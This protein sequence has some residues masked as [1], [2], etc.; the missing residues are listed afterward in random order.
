[1]FPVPV[2]SDVGGCQVDGM[3]SCSLVQ[4]K[5]GGR[6]GA[7]KNIAGRLVG[8]CSARLEL[9]GDVK[10]DVCDSSAAAELSSL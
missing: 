2:L 8:N 1:M 10:G 6:S 5:Q 7:K 3:K 4:R 9:K